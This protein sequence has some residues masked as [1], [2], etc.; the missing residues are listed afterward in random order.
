[1]NMVKIIEFAE[2]KKVLITKV[3]HLYFIIHVFYVS[4]LYPKVYHDYT[5]NNI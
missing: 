2:F 4:Y 5:L 1:M 3:I